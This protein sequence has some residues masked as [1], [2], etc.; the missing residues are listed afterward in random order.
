MLW[1]RGLVRTTVRATPPVAQDDGDRAIAERAAV[2]TAPSRA[3][4]TG[5]AASLTHR[6]G[7]QPFNK[8]SLRPRRLTGARGGMKIKIGPAGRMPGCIKLRPFPLSSIRWRRGSGRGGPLLLANRAPPSLPA[9][10]VPS[11]DIE[12][13]AP[14]GRMCPVSGGEGR[15]DSLDHENPSV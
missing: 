12:L 8:R 7:S 13:D 1:K 11:G 14:L 5:A 2:P 10:P 4:Y 6:S 9:S 3:A 15:T